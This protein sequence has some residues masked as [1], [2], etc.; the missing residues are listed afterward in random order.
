MEALQPLHE[1]ADTMTGFATRQ[2]H[3][4]IWLSSS[5]PVPTRTDRTPF[6]VGSGARSSSFPALSSLLLAPRASC[7]TRNVC[8]VLGA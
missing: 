4:N 5:R 7:A 6:S 1:P 8:A 2:R 3:C